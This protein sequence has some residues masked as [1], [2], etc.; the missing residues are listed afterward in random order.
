MQPSAPDVPVHHVPAYRRV[1]PI[2][3]PTGSAVIAARM[4]TAFAHRTWSTAGL[5]GRARC[6]AF[7]VGHGRASFTGDDGT[8]IDLVA[9]VLLWLPRPAVGAFQLL[10]GSDGVTLAV[11]EDFV[12]RTVGDSTLAAHLR[13]MLERVVIAPAERIAPHLAE[14]GTAF[15]ALVRESRDQ[16]PGASAMMALHLGLVLLH[17]W[18]A[19]GLG[20][21]TAGL[22]GT[23]ATTAQRFRQLTELHYRENL[24]IDD[25]ASM[26]GVTRAHLHD[27]CLRTTGRTPLGLVHDRLVSEAKLRLEQTQVPVEQV[28]YGLGFRDPGY[29][30]RFFKRLVGQSPGAFRQAAAAAHPAGEPTSFAAWP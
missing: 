26:L 5:D 20:T 9:P 27:A 22:R 19:S 13:L 23:A 4:E 6:H 16:P 25:Y 12:W 1:Q 3:H 15:S 8:T 30:S 24:R 29:F 18:R 28:G 21:A 17:L 7:F 10:A 14:L 2:S 11:A